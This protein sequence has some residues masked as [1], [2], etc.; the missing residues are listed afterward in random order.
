MWQNSSFAGWCV[1]F[2]AQRDV[3]LR[4]VS[5]RCVAL[6][7]VAAP[8]AT[9]TSHPPPPPP[10][11]GGACRAGVLHSAQC[12]PGIHRAPSRSA[13]WCTVGRSRQH[14]TEG[15]ARPGGSRPTRTARDR[16]HS[17][18]I[19]YAGNCNSLSTQTQHTQGI[20]AYRMLPTHM[21]LS[22]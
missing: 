20:T 21:A 12:T 4:G 13:E 1:T 14:C 7:H 11:V 19:G 17:R 16:A 3:A 6:H 9:I 10:G 8:P 15:T 18:Y 5:L 22:L 2:R